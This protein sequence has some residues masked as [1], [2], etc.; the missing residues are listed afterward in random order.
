MNV[1][2][3]VRC[4][5]RGVGGLLV[6]GEVVDVSRADGLIGVAVA[7]RSLDLTRAPRLQFFHESDL[8]RR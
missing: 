3:Q 6:I 5:R 7:R 8:A 4:I 2:D 1:G